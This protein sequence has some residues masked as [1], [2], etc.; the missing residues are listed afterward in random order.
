[1][2][3]FGMKNRILKELKLGQDFRVYDLF[4][5]RW[6]LMNSELILCTKAEYQP[7]HR[8]N[9]NWWIQCACVHI[10]KEC[11]Y[12]KNNRGWIEPIYSSGAQV[13]VTLHFLDAGIERLHIKIE[14]V[15]NPL[16]PLFPE[17]ILW[18][19]C[20]KDF[21]ARTISTILIFLPFMLFLLKRI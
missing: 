17:V 12:L 20:S 7:T 21:S 6:F 9:A 1:M 19:G 8:A 16:K 13:N 5:E 4:N 10:R 14:K 2:S 11:T 15:R 3:H 18:G